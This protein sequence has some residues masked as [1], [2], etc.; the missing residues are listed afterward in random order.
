MTF[1]TFP[2]HNTKILFF[3]LEYYVP[4]GDRERNIKSGLSFSPVLS[5]HK[6]LGGCFQFYYPIKNVAEHK[7]HHVW[8]WRE[9]SEEQV[10]KLIYKKF[11]KLWKGHKPGMASPMVCGIG[12][13][14][15]DIPV[16]FSKMIQYKV[17]SPE[18]IFDLLYGTRQIDLSSIVACQF[19]SKHNYLFYPK[20]KSELYRK[21][22]PQAQKYMEK[23]TSVWGMYENR[24][25]EA[26]ENR[27]KLEIIDTLKIYKKI[28]ETR[29]RIEN[30]LKQK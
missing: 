25:F 6:L 2:K 17:D 20:T 30:Q 22:Y 12:I 5:E 23:G 4:K 16:L 19:S 14:H 21:Y 29:K 1:L 9:S 8:E 10:V 27:T 28:F 24:N 3:D 11:Q 7:I 15:S 18:N 13:S 26:I